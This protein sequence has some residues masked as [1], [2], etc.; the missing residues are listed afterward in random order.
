[1]TGSY[2]MACMAALMGKS[3]WGR[4]A[5]SIGFAINLLIFILIVFSAHRLPIFGDFESITT[6]SLVL[7]F[8]HLLNFYCSTPTDRRFYDAHAKWIYVSIILLLTYLAFFPKALNQDFYMYDDIMVIVFFHFRILASGVFIYSASILCA[9]LY[10]GF[11]GYIHMGRNFLLTGAAIF[12]ISEFSGSLWC[13]NWHGDSWHWSK[14]FLKASCLFLVA[15]LACHIP[16]SW[17]LSN[18][19]LAI[20]GSIPAAGS[21]L[22][23]FLH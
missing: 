18:R 14:G 4:Y 20:I 22:L 15:I 1:M 2:A 13:L 7:G 3:Q 8:L 9:A 17:K 10:H 6:I 16:A 11:P 21:I 23:L 12:L 19:I 5:G